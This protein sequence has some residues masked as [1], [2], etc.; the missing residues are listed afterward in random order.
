MKRVGELSAE[1]FARLFFFLLVGPFAL[2]YFLGFLGLPLPGG[3]FD[4]WFMG[5][6]T[7]GGIISTAGLVGSVKR[8]GLSEL[9]CLVPLAAITI[10]WGYIFLKMIGATR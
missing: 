6:L 4:I 9:G 5:A 10:W 7:A 2:V 3:W 8:H 1:W